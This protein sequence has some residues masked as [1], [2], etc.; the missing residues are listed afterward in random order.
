MS[1][2]FRVVQRAALEVLEARRLRFPLIPAYWWV[3]A[4]D[5]TQWG[6]EDVEGHATEAEVRSMRRALNKLA[7]A[8][9]VDLARSKW[10]DL[11]AC[12]SKG[13][14]GPLDARQQ[15]LLDDR[16][17]RITLIAIASRVGLT[18][19]STPLDATPAGQYEIVSAH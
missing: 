16:M 5:L 4:R 10:G 6:I 19:C 12:A 7:V 15:K 2:G 17:A 18:L 13:Y 14:D 11:V 1:T 8:G 9:R 3:S